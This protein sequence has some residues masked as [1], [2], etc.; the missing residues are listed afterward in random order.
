MMNSAVLKQKQCDSMVLLYH[1]KR[2]S[3][4]F[5]LVRGIL[6]NI[7]AVSGVNYNGA[8]SKQT[9]LESFPSVS[10][11]NVIHG[12]RLQRQLYFGDISSFL[13]QRFSLI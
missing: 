1:C 4:G 10:A 6:L 12:S 7:T 2:H 13:H 3:E 9:F 5:V 8:D 11:C